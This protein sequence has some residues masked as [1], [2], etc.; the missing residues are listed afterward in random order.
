MGTGTEEEYF[1]FGRDVARLDFTSH[2]GNDFQ[3]TDDDW[4][5]LNDTVRRFHADGRFVV[6]PG[7]EWSANSTVGGDRNVFYFEEDLP[8]IRS[9]PWQLDPR[10]ACNLHPHVPVNALFDALRRTVDPAK[11]I[12]GSHVGG[13]FA[14]IKLGF[15]E[16]L[17]PLIE[18][19]SCWGVFEWL[20]H[21][22]IEQ[23][24]L[25]AVMANSDGH[26]GR[27]GAEGPGAG[28]FGIAGGMTCVL[29]EDLSRQ[30]IFNALKQRRCYGTTGARIH[31]DFT[32]NEHTMGSV[33]ERGPLSVRASAIGA[34]PLERLQLYRGKQLIREVAAPA[35]TK[36]N[37]SERVRVM[38]Q[39]SLCSQRCNQNAVLSRRREA[40]RA[41]HSKTCPHCRRT[42]VERRKDGVYCSNACRQA[43]HRVR[44]R[45]GSR[46]FEKTKMREPLRERREKVDIH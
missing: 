5:R 45:H 21:D 9:S 35:F 23:G 32:V 40:R 29:A 43:S 12:C 34:A 44:V 39:G 18:V 33:I 4:R 27:P 2:Q 38:W 42:F 1:T 22:A 31:L 17:G 7:Y 6:F 14:D 37:D 36:L 41:E 28:E 26:K 20:L 46:P 16:T 3:M 19:V 15:D 13:R 11:V 24:H 25:F 8:I 30:A 10:E